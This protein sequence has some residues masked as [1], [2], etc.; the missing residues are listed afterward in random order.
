MGLFTLRSIVTDRSEIDLRR[1]SWSV[2]ITSQH[3]QFLLMSLRGSFRIRSAAHRKTIGILFSNKM[4]AENMNMSSVVLAAI[5]TNYEKTMQR[6]RVCFRKQHLKIINQLR[7]NAKKREAVMFL[8]FRALRNR[9]FTDRR[10]WVQETKH[11]G[12]FWEKTVALWKEDS[13]WL[14][15]FR[16]S[17]GTFEFLCH[18]IS[19][20][21]LHQDTRFRKAI[22]VE[23]RVAICIWHLAT[24]EDFRSL[25]WRFGVGK[26]TACEI[27]NNVCEAIVDILLPTVIKWPS[28][29][30]LL[31]VRDGFL[32]TWG[33][34][35]CGGV[36]DGTHIPIV[37]PPQSA[38]DFYNRKGFYSI[39][40][41]AV[42][43][44]QYRYDNTF[45]Q[46]HTEICR[47]VSVLQY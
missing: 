32:Q 30:A 45:T 28:G 10:L 42:V 46:L 1:V 44:H 34:P 16:M 47:I 18:K 35:Q 41:Q 31:T 39:V 13:L 23:K 27:V 22:S 24:G 14:E 21:L 43:D 5:I 40:L 6:K 12:S 7:R 36:I 25:A 2:H 37:A 15:N 38:T 3:R 20:N 11:I 19:G 9:L 8:Y 4:A 33:F 17:R 26:S 29:E